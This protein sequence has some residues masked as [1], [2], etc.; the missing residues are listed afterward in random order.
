LPALSARSIGLG[1]N[2]KPPIDWG[3][4]N[5]WRLGREKSACK[6]FSLSRVSLFL[7]EA[8]QSYFVGFH[9]FSVDPAGIVV[10][11]GL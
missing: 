2:K 10:D 8:N 7:A 4:K 1:S 3:R 9:L 6:N 5:G 11:F